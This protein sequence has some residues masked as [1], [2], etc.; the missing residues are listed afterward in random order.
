MPIKIAATGTSAGKI[1]AREAP[2]ARTA[3]V[4][5][6]IA[7]TPDST[8][9]T[10]AWMASS[11]G[12][13]AR[14]R[15]KLPKTIT[16]GSSAAAE[17]TETTAVPSMG[18]TCHRFERIVNTAHMTPA[19][20]NIAS[21]S[22]V[23]ASPASSPGPAMTASPSMMTATPSSRGRPGRSFSTIQASSTEPSVT[24]AGWI[25]APCASGA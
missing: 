13:S 6:M 25:S 23:S 18:P 12:G 10:S 4:K 16:S 5:A 11:A 24:V 7:T 1:A 9:C 3:A 2:S 20:R 21:P 8:P 17:S 22:G 19:R 14:M 15:S